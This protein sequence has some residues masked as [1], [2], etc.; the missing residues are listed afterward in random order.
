M[1]SNH[2]VA[3]C[4]WCGPMRGHWAFSVQRFGTRVSCLCC[5][6]MGP[7]GATEEEAVENW[8]RGVRRDG[9]V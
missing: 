1:R 5:D 3:D 6:C 4:P 7:R 2:Q 8:N 9:N